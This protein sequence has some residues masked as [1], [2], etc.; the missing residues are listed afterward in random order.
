MDLEIKADKEGLFEI[1][2]TR[3]IRRKLSG[4]PYE[5][6]SYEN[7]DWDTEPEEEIFDDIGNQVPDE[8]DSLDQSQQENK[9]KKEDKSEE[10]GNSI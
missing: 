2:P 9:E 3:P 1:R 8:N 10:N 6:A 7:D 5:Q 4:E